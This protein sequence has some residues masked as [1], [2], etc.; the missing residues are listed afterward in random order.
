MGFFSTEYIITMP[1]VKRALTIFV[2]RGLKI[3][4]TVN[5]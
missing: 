5:F 2:Y 4:P 1:K 3:I